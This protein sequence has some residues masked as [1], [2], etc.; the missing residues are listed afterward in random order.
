MNLLLSIR[1]Y[2]IVIFGAN[3][4]IPAAS[5]EICDWIK[6]QYP[7][8]G[9][10]DVVIVTACLIRSI[11]AMHEVYPLQQVELNRAVYGLTDD[12]YKK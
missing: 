5:L 6:S 3:S 7:S 10:E 12:R 11:K 2:L 9:S 1:D 4:S 8:L